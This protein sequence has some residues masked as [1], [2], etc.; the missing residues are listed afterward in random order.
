MNLG[1]WNGRCGLGLITGQF[2][3]FVTGQF[4]QFVTGQFVTDVF[5][6]GNNR[7]TRSLVVNNTFYS[8]V[9]MCLFM[10]TTG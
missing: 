8:S 3:Q 9:M 6:H 1:R 4:V 10:S 2:V 5:V 7:V